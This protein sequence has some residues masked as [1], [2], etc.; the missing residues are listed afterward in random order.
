MVFA[1]TQNTKNIQHLIV[2]GV[3]QPNSPRS[4]MRLPSAFAVSCPKTARVQITPAMI[5]RCRV[6]HTLIHGSDAYGAGE[7]DL[8]AKINVHNKLG[9]R[10][11]EGSDITATTTM[12]PDIPVLICDLFPGLLR[13]GRKLVHVFQEQG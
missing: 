13:T 9:G 5:V 2:K 10:M 12:Y 6:P 11:D 4:A 1:S 3:F 8:V 7:T